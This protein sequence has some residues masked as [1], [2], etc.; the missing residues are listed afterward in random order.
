[1][2]HR[3]MAILVA[4]LTA[5]W[6]EAPCHCEFGGASGRLGGTVEAASAATCAH[7]AHHHRHHHHEG[8]GACP[9]HPSGSSEPAD[10][11]C[12]GG[13]PPQLPPPPAP[14]PPLPGVTEVHWLDAGS[15]LSWRAIGSPGHARIDRF[16]AC[17]RASDTLLRRHCA[18]IV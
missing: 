16:A 15:P 14:A 3:A 2:K 10:H 18:L 5:V 8:D 9:F 6:L 13:L 17:D 7:A 4:F 1:M 12:C 11:C